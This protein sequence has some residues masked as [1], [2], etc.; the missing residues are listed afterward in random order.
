MSYPCRRGGKAVAAGHGAC[1]DRADS[2]DMRTAL[3]LLIL[4]SAPAPFDR[5][6]NA[7]LGGVYLVGAENAHEESCEWLG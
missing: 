6:E 3:V 1:P 5:P 7:L 4:A 2:A